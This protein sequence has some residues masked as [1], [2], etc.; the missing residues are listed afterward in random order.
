MQCQDLEFRPDGL[1][2]VSLPWYG[3]QSALVSPGY[4]GCSTRPSLASPG[5]VGC[6]AR[7]LAGKG[8]HDL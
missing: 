3:I 4:L 8:V 7:P 6:S 5:Y 1:V 2:L